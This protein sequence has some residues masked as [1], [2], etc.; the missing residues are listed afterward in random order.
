MIYI[1]FFLGVGGGIQEKRH[2]VSTFNK[3]RW[4]SE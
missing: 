2:F 1:L 4:H 3:E